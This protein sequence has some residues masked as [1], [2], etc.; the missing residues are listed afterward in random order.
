MKV[1]SPAEL[2]DTYR[3]HLLDDV[4]PFWFAAADDNAGGVFTCWNNEGTALVSQNKYIWSQGR[5]AWLMARL[6][7][8]GRC[9]LLPVDA[10]LCLE[11]AVRTAEF[12]KNHVLLEGYTTA[13]VT[14]RSG[15]P[16]PD[17]QGRLHTSIFAD[18]FVALGF[19]GV[20]EVSGDHA[21]AQLADAMLEAASARVAAGP[22]PTEPYPIRAGFEAFSLPMILVGTGTQVFR[23]T[24]SPHAAS[25]VRE[26]AGT[27][28]STFLHGDDMSE[29]VPA[30]PDDADTQL[31][32]HR[33]P[34]HVL[35]ALWFLLDA[36]D[37]LA[38][39][40]EQG[41]PSLE[42]AEALVPIALR[43][44]ALGRDA[45]QGGFLRYVDRDGGE[46]RGRRT[47]DSYEDLVART[48]DTK[49]WWTHSEALY[50]LLRLGMRTG[51]DDL[52]QAHAEM[53]RFVMTTFP[54]GPGREWIQI[55]DRAGAPL[56][57]TVALP[58]KDP[59]HIAR[60]LLLLV[61]CLTQPR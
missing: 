51:R 39:G 12:L 59:F 20:A 48:W 18:F 13:Y 54:A 5:W 11:R 37:E 42:L 24:R 9:G 33:T 21:F 61:E 34:G 25:I 1:P 35:E 23:A 28:A 38:A 16:L 58:V 36:T 22:V 14:D 27:M 17:V 55:R 2:L 47:D 29:L 31:A 30:S 32:R 15:R 50:A 44:Y 26:A 57:A 56:D 8:A 60:A 46:P 3:R 52:L 40:G 43:S 7:L 19:A 10:D 6:A 49:L 45:E 41:L 53:H 4:L